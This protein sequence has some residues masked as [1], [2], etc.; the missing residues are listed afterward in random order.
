[1]SGIFR[2][3][4]ADCFSHAFNVCIV[5]SSTKREYHAGLVILGTGKELRDQPPGLSVGH[6]G[7]GVA[8]VFSTATPNYPKVLWPM[9]VTVLR[10]ASRRTMATRLE[11]RR[12]VRV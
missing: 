11:K 5:D 3:W 9:V 8:D 10:L 1:M 6:L 7:T 4:K 2:T 12:E